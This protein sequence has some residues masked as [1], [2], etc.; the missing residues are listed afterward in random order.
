VLEN[1]FIVMEGRNPRAVAEDEYALS[2]RSAATALT[3][4]F[5]PG[6]DEAWPGQA[7]GMVTNWKLKHGT[8]L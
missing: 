8:E 1:L 2:S 7:E 5:R 4:G 3:R 6:E